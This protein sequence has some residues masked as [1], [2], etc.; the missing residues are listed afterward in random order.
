MGERILIVE[1]DDILREIYS[2]KFSME[3]FE[4]YAAADGQEALEQAKAH[5]PSLI[6]LD[7]LMPRVSGLE[8]LRIYH[9]SAETGKAKVLV[10]SNKSS[11][12]MIAQ[13]MALGACDYL[14][15]SRLTPDEIVERA[16]EHLLAETTD[17]I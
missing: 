6:L 8:F 14:I 2:T 13:A 3:H 15:K 10:A 7:M 4:V 16:R 11:E 5:Q 1:D 12:D 9:D 17:P